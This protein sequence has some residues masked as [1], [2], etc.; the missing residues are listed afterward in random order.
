MR[1]L[2]FLAAFLFS[3]LLGLIISLGLAHL[4]I[5]FLSAQSLSAQNVKQVPPKGTITVIKPGNFP[6]RSIDPSKMEM[7]PFDR[8]VKGTEKIEGLFTFY[9]DKEEGS[10]YAE[11]KPEQLD[12]NYLIAI[13]Q[14]SGIGERGIYSGLPLDSF[15]FRFHRVK[16]SLQLIS[17]NINIRARA[18]NPEARSVDR[19]FSDSILSV[20]PIGSIH[21]QRQTVLID[22]GSLL[23]SDFP[24]ITA[25][26][27]A[28][29]GG[30]Y[31]IDP[32][33]SR[34]DVVKGFPGNVE[35]DSVLGFS[36]SPIDPNG[37]AAS[38]TALP[39]SRAFS[40]KI[41][42]SLSQLP[43][44]T[45]YRPRLADDRIGY[46]ITAYQDFSKNTSKTPFV[47]YIDRWRLEKQDPKAEL[48]PPKKQIV[49]WL[50]NTIPLEYRDPIRDGVLMWNKAFEQ[51]GF[52]D[53]IEVKQMP[54]NATWDPA[55]IRYNTIR[56]L[57]SLDA[58]FAMGPSR[59]NP[60]TGEILD[61]DIIVDSNLIRSQ[62]ESYQNL[63][64]QNHAS[65]MPSLARR[66]GNS[67]LC[68]YGMASQYL[69]AVQ[70]QAVQSQSWQFPQNNISSSTNTNRAASRNGRRDSEM[71]YGMQ[72]K[73]QFAVGSLGLSLIRNALPSSVE[74]KDYTNQF[75]RQL[76]AHEVGHTLGL[77]HNFRAS[78]MLK[79]EDLNNTEIT[80]TKGLVSSVMDY[81]PANLAPQGKP[82]GDYF[83]RIVGP[84]D[85]WA[86]E[87]GYKPIEAIVPQAELQELE[88]I[89][90]R[91]PEPD[92]AYAT[93]ED[94]MAGI[95]PNISA[96]DLSSDMLTYAQSQLD[97]AR[98]M[99]QRLERRY[100]GKGES[101]SEVTS[102]FDRVFGY[103]FQYSSLLTNYVGGQSFN[104]YRSGDAKGR[105]PLEP[106]PVDKQ[107]QAL[108]ILQKNVF[109]PDAL[110]FSP[111][112]LNKLAPA[113]WEHWGENATSMLDYPIHE[114]ILFFQ[115]IVLSDLLSSDRLN[116]LR[117]LELKTKPQAAITLPELFDT[118]QAGI[119]TEVMPESKSIQISSLRRALQRQY[120]GILTNMTL[121]NGNPR[122]ARSFAEFISLILTSNAPEDARSVAWYHLRQ[123]KDSIT[124]TLN[125]Q[126]GN[127]DTYTKIHLEE[128]VD[129]IAKILDSRLQ[130]Q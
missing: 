45:G 105:S 32:T 124:S 34:L 93:D 64:Q 61:A 17:P 22:L 103:Y 41:H 46:F 112:F 126:G 85:R 68:N 12:R 19:S 115:T 89:A 20:L 52:K 114:N 14:N 5:E 8:V 120:M 55:D 119:W 25:D 128:S 27:S 13:T 77:R 51:I 127:L 50:E 43:E 26:L 21:P 130:S 111:S 37:R 69:Q 75:L 117:D 28:S 76:I 116:R 106:I 81:I 122:N 39:D 47:R 23:M 16:D 29:L 123:L 91:A 38:V 90:R 31:T 78:A 7:L 36:G 110:N 82:Q 54:D 48:S 57:S 11:I 30:A 92:L 71:C 109:D 94:L 33:K 66:L 88:K 62:K 108:A 104:R 101:Y 97:N 113:R 18:G 79:P 49:Y 60:L 3:F 2:S 67:G 6:P 99:W 96:F 42:Y 9:R 74:A 35:I 118:L 70:S 83:T 1:R 86:I 63:V 84:Y 24:G 72:A 4:P 100:P 10:L 58:A 80:H 44:K 129:R 53:A 107:R 59:V 15:I 73:E 56:W 40:L 121:R 98:V 102:A 65:I 125:K 95:D 87:Y